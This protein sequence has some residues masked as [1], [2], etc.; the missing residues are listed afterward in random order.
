[1][2]TFIK[3]EYVVANAFCELLTG[4]DKRE[5]SFKQIKDYGFQVEKVLSENNNVNAVLLFSDE[6]KKQL[7]RDYT[8]LFDYKDD[9]IILRQ[10]KN[11]HDVQDRI[12]SFASF[13]LLIALFDSTSIA[14][15]GIRK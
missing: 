15:L 14:K 1:M 6:Y 8:D 7:L 2:C 3:M 9:L 11:M 13:D 4:T 5:I 12:L 10:G